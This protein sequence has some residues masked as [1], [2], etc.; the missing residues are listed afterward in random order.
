MKIPLG[1]FLDIYEFLRIFIYD[2]DFNKKSFSLITF[3]V[4]VIRIVR[5]WENQ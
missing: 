1:R 4:F 2:Y 3:Q 5:H